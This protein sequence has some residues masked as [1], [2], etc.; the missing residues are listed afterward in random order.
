[1]SDQLK[2][3]KR[4]SH[5]MIRC[6]ESGE[7]VPA[8]VRADAASLKTGDLGKQTVKCPHCGQEHTWSVKDAWIE[9]VL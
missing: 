1:M 6:P 5:V 7:Q 4:L 3:A 8:G 2:A 9:D